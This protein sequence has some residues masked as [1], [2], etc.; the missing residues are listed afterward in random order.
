M[1]SSFNKVKVKEHN[2]STAYFVEFCYSHM[3]HCTRLQLIAANV[4]SASVI[5]RGHS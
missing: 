4:P 1:A 5:S 2:A 3:L